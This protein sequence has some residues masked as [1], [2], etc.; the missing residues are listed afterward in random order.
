MS[1]KPSQNRDTKRIDDILEKESTPPMS[2]AKLPGNSRQVL[3]AALIVVVY[4]GLFFILDLLSKQF[5]ELKGIVAWYP[6]AGLTYVLLLVFGARFSPAVTLALLISS[7]FVYRMSQPFYLLLLWA[8][9]ISLIYTISAFL[10]RKRFGFDWQ[11]RKM[12]DV[13]FLVAA[14]IF[15]SAILAILSVSSSALSSNIPR[16]EVL[17]STI[18]WWIGETVGV[19]TVAPVMLM[20][21]MPWLKRFTDRRTAKMPPR[22]SLPRLKLSILGQA[23]SMALVFYL[24]FN[25]SGLDEFRPLYFITLPLIWIAL[26][27]GLKGVTI[28]IVVANFGITLA[29]WLAR[30]DLSHIGELQLLMI[31]NCII[32]LLMGAVVTE[33]KRT[34]EVL[35]TSENQFR[36]F[37][38]QAAVGVALIETKTGRYIDINKKYCDFLGFSKEEMCNSSFLQVTHPADVQENVD[39][40]TLL[41][42]GKIA[43]FSIEKRYIR[44]DGSIVWGN[45]AVAPLWLPGTVPTEFTHIAVVQDITERK[46]TIQ[47][48]HETKEYLD[49]LVDHT[50]APIVIWNSDMKITRLNRAFERLTGYEGGEILGQE[51]SLLFPEVNQIDSLIKITPTPGGEPWESIEISL[52]CQN[53][54]TKITIWNSAKICAQDGVTVVSTIAQVQDITERKYTEAKNLTDQTELQLLLSEARA[55]R[56]A[57]LSLA[58]DQGRGREEILQ[59]N[60]SLEQKV[61]DRTAQLEISNTELEA[62]A[63]S[64]S[65]DLRAPLRAIDGFSRI[66]QQ[67]YESKLDSEGQRLLE[68]IRSNTGVMD[69][70]ITD[71]LALSRVS[72]SELNYSPIDMTTMANSIYHELATPQDLEKFKF[73]V[74][75]LPQALGD[76]TLMRQVWANLISNALKY[77][78]P[79]QDCVIEITG[80][81]KGGYCTYMVKDNGVGFNPEYSGKLF[82]LF[83]RLHKAGEF[84]GTGVGLTIVQRIVRRH[85]GNVAGEGKI[86]EGATFTFSIPERKVNHE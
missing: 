68:I 35:R 15:V 24:V 12:R 26:D 58:E 38:E 20:H 11:L 85:G 65:H 41:I 70:L 46:K 57:L 71:L 73:K 30:F 79:K 63:Y 36:T 78:L 67:E 59:L 2:D 39:K 62:F 72:R 84:E 77:T 83:Q 50:N 60:Q 25:V 37:F 16:N 74:N 3:R 40:N 33:R 45:L 76:P 54:E 6:P 28:G 64:V 21:V 19:L 52:L 1:R 4:L 81:K 8:F 66:L 14:A 9:I 56:R 22:R 13:A 31:V 17:R 86:G 53:G 5:E 61:K 34:E 23:F 55:S 47:N 48:L 18:L 82:K 43:E 69:H 29:M 27:H 75:P 10:L 80:H 32:G 42:E 51:L 49:K 7:L 44:K